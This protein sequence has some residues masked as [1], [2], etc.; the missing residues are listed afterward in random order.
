MVL[1]VSSL[2]QQK[3]A[4]TILATGANQQVDIGYAVGIEVIAERLFGDI[5]G[6]DTLSDQPPRRIDNLGSTPVIE[7]NVED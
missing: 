2:P 1:A 7:G 5:F 3:I 6:P 4:Q